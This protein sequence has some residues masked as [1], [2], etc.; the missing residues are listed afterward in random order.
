MQSNSFDRN[1]HGSRV[2]HAGVAKSDI[3]VRDA[4]VIVNDPLYAKVLVLD[5]GAT[6]AVIIAMDVTAI[7]GIGDVTD[8]FL[9]QLRQRIE[10]ELSIDGSHVLVNA[11]HTHPPG[12]LVC[13]ETE[14]LD[15]TFDAVLRAHRSMM[16]V[17]VGSGS[18]REDQ[19][20]MNRNLKMKDGRH[21]TIRHTNPSPP[22]EQVVGVGPIDPEIGVVRF[23]RMNG[24]PLAVIYNFACH[25]LFGALGGR[26]TA[27]YPG[28]A[29]K[30]IEDSLGNGAMALFLQGAG[31]DVIDV[32]FKEFNQT[33][34]IEPMATKLGLCTLETLKCIESKEARLG[35]ISKTSQLPRRTDILER[36][37]V[38]RNEQA[39]LLESLRYTMLNLKTF[40]PMYLKHLM[41]PQFP[42]TNSYGYLQA[43]KNN[44]NDLIDMD[45][46]NK[47]GVEKYLENIYTMEKLARIQDEIMTYERHQAINDESGEKTIDAEV[48]GLKI[49]DCVIITAPIEVLTEVGL[50]VKNASP[51]EHTF[52]AAFTNGYMH[53]GPPA[54][55]YDKG[56]YEVIECFLAPEWQQAYEQTAG[57]I[58]RRL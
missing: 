41:S 21:W 36:L 34:N 53:Y 31:G 23:D 28:I 15:K 32:Y 14:L 16:P 7:G 22:D 5:D 49:G 42:G 33:R 1:G 13:G 2:L 9:P 46:F 40:L 3:T 17:R 10:S 12:R 24:S 39:S 20:T 38:L 26:V 54:A 44:N 18:G 6:C 52:M 30:I 25:P 47:R 29:S 56:G 8:D 37:Q 4:S 35:L 55:D 43:E 27:D 11:S 51:Y 19:I 45:S 58:I 57:D 50:N 48:V